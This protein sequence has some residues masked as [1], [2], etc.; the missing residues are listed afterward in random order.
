MTVSGIN[1]SAVRF[2]RRRPSWSQGFG[3]TRMV[4]ERLCVV[5]KQDAAT[6]RQ[7][8]EGN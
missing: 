4:F 1:W 6:S 8:F 5:G 3:N 2:K 7:R